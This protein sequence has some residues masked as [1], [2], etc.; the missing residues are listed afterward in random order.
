[1]NTRAARRGF[2]WLALALLLLAPAFIA[3]GVWQVHR[4][5]WKEALIAHVEQ[6][7][8]ARRS[9]WRCFR[10]ARSPLE[11]RCLTM[12]GT[13]DARGVT[14]VTGTSPGSGYWVL[15]PLQ[16]DRGPPVLVNRG[17]GPSGPR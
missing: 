3:L 6:A 12:S 7:T 16:P 5:A 1:L 2:N 4:L 15:D 13:Y 17:F 10:K 9:R 14:L 8:H 11:Y